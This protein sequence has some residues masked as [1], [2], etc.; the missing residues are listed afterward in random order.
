MT[1][2]LS[3][4]I[5]CAGVAHFGILI[6][7]FSVPFVMDWRHMLK[8][9]PKLMRQLIWVYGGYVVLMIVSLGAVSVLLSNDL[10]SGT[11]LA[12]SVCGFATLFWGVRLL[13]QFAYFDSQEF[14]TSWWLNA[15]YHSLTVAFALL[16]CIFTVAAF[17]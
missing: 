7:S 14:R 6:A 5:W 16:T 11:P 15:G 9:L 3:F 10:A 4:W 1:E 13:L 2:H 17:G 12:R 8:P